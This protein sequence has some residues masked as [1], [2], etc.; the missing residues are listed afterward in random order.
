MVKKKGEKRVC[1][2]PSEVTLITG[3]DKCMDSIFR[4]PHMYRCRVQVFTGECAVALPRADAC[5]MGIKENAT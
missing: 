4:G 2:D 5:S 1:R 3:K